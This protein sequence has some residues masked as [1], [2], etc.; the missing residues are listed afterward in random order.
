MYSRFFSSLFLYQT[1]MFILLF[2]FS[3]FILILKEQEALEFDLQ[4]FAKKK[5]LQNY[6]L[7]CKFKNEDT[8][9]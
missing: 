7:S 8:E 1:D 4:Y 9:K 6:N 3:F 2:F 5:Q